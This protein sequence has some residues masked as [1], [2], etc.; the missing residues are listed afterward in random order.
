LL[1][2]F[3]PDIESITLA[4]SDGGRFEFSID[5]KLVY[6]KLETHRHTEPGEIAGMVRKHLK[7]K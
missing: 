3:E 1:K 7:A 5:G 6:S 2:E 4:P